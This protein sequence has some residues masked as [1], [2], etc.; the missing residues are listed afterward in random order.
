[1]KNLILIF[2]LALTCFGCVTVKDG[3]DPLLVRAEQIAETAYDSMDAFVLWEYKNRSVLTPDVKASADLVREFGPRYLEA[4]RAAT[5][6]YKAERTQPNA[7]Q[8]QS[9]IN[10]L[11]SLLDDAR[12]YY[13]K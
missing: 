13:L 4:V 10:V 7:Q 5:R 6:S 9:A 12:N 1:M 3:S 11:Q 2:L 8:L